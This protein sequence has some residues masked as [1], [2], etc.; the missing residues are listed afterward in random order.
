M[1][2]WLTS[3]VESFGS[4]LGLA[5]QELTQVVFQRIIYR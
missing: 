4:M 5:S 3:L 1:A 2:Y